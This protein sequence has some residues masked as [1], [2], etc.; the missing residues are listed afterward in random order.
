MFINFNSLF[1]ESFCLNLISQGLY[2][3]YLVFKLYF[4]V[5]YFYTV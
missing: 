3:V 1:K 5:I 4:H 2:L